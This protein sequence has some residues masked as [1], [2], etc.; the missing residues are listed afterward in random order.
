MYRVE[1]DKWQD[2]SG[3]FDDVD[4][5]NCELGGPLGMTVRVILVML[6]D[7][8]RRTLI[9]VGPFLG[10]QI[11]NYIKWREPS[12]H[13]AAFISVHR[14]WTQGGQLLPALTISTSAPWGTTHQTVSQN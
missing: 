1:A 6:T 14:L 12:E 2:C 3:H 5:V 11:L 9:V 13:L 8:R 4:N 7:F 10:Q